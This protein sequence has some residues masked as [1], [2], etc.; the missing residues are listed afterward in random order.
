LPADATAA[1]ALKSS[2]RLELAAPD[3]SKVVLEAGSMHSFT[4]PSM[5]SLGQLRRLT[6]E[7]DTQGAPKVCWH[8]GATRW[9]SARE[10]AKHTGW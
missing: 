10:L 1:A 9:L 8:V 6:L 3:G 4:L 2:G 7:L 5:A